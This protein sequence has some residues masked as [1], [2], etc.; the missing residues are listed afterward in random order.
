MSS[1]VTATSPT[2]KSF[3]VMRKHR[4]KSLAINRTIHPRLPTIGSCC[5]KTDDVNSS[6]PS[7]DVLNTVKKINDDDLNHS[8]VASPTSCGINEANNCDMQINN[9]FI[10][11][12]PLQSPVNDNLNIDECFNQENATSPLPDTSTINNMCNQLQMP[13]SPGQL[14]RK[15]FYHFFICC[16]YTV[17]NV[18]LFYFPYFFL[19]I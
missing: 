17:S 18:F 7:L 9:A 16:L 11:P 13:L 10:F 12:T 15:Y 4:S 19:I 3:N 5:V 8:V 14:G 1:P 6:I 2:D